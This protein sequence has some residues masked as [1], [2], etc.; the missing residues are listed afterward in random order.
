MASI[1]KIA[2]KDGTTSYHVEIRKS[3][4][5]HIGKTFLTEEDANLFIFYK[6]RLFTNMDSF[7]VD[8]KDMVTIKQL[9]EL[10]LKDGKDL[11]HKS[12]LD[13]KMA[14]TRV[15]ENFGE[16]TY[17]ETITYDLW[18]QFAKKLHASDVFK[19]AKTEVGRRPM[20]VSN[21]RKIF[22]LVSSA[23]SYAKST[24]INIQ[25]HPLQ[26]LQTYIRPL[27]SK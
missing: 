12:H 24:G 22:A 2:L 8:I 15:N 23:I 10:K 18:L 11:C 13:F 14:L 9:I 16:E 27:T 6:E 5:D 21:L 1:R 20:S 26:V 4:Q 17:L 7:E 3:G 19:G 25:N